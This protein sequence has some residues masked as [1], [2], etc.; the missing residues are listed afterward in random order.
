MRGVFFTK[1]KT[2]TKRCL[3]YLVE[4]EEDVLAV[5]LS[6]KESYMNTDLIALAKDHGIRVI[7]YAEC[8][9]FFAENAGLIEMIWCNTFPKRIKSAWIE[10]A[11]VAAVNFHVAP[12]PDYRGVFGFNFAFLNGEKEFGVTAHMLDGDFDTGAIIEVE[13]FPFDF[14]SGSVKELVELSEEH[15]FHLFKRVCGRFA[16]GEDVI[17]EEQDLSKGN[18]YSRDDFEK[19]KIITPSDT[20]EDIQRKVRAFWFPPYEGAY[21]PWEGKRLPVVT[22][23]VLDGLR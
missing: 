10:T 1:P 5:V 3:E 13:R 11:S 8:D 7:D 2:L 22:K 21:V 15:M 4:S 18:Y 16:R 19:S 14:E 12:L 23:E 9:A 6:G 20:M 17:A